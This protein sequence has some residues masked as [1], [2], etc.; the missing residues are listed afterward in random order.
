[1][2][3]SVGFQGRMWV[4]PGVEGAGGKFAYKE[5]K[6]TWEQFDRGC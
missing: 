3:S 4:R 2:L 1:M 6:G 5:V